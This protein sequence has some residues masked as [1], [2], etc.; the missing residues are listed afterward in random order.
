MHVGQRARP[1]S[2]RS[3]PVT[4][5]EGHGKVTILIDEHGEVTQARLHIVE[6]RGFERFI[7]GRPY[8]EVPGHRPAALRHLPGQPP[9]RRRQGHGP[10]RG[11]RAAHPHRREDPPPDALRPDLPVPR[12]AL[13]PPLQPRPAVRHDGTASSAFPAPV[14]Q[15]NVMAVAAKYPDLAVQG[16]MMRR[17]GQEIIKATAG[18][19][20]H[21]TGAIPGGVNKNLSIAERDALLKDVEQMIEWSRG[22]REDRPGL[23][24][25]P[26]RRSSSRSARSIPTTCRSSARPTARWTSTTA[27]CAPWTRTG[28]TI[29]DDVDYQRYLDVVAEEVRP[30]SYM[31][32]PFLKALGPENGLVPGGAAGAAQHLRLHRH[33]RSRGRAQ[34]F[35]ALTAW[36]AEQRHH[37]LPLGA[38][39]RAAPLHREDP[40]PPR[41][42]RPPGHRPGRLTA[43]AARRRSASSR[44]RAARCSTTT[45]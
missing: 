39:D 21:G 26:S 15:R 22:A 11:R 4:R 45:G 42:P 24:H 32:F 9:P 36:Q 20:I 1:A 41:R 13:L 8:W 14:A 29:F 44:R 16:V 35:V 19:K 37:G 12:A 25:G 2:T 33:A 34:E 17:Y 40:R 38:D 30:W 43:R 3:S 18:K 5:V 7:Q 28:A 31:K 6:F 10:D 23:H 27:S